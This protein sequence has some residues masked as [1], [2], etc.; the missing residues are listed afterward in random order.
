MTL[1]VTTETIDY[2]NA[3][4]IRVA[5]DSGLLEKKDTLTLVGG[6]DSLLL[7]D[8]VVKI[9]AL[10]ANGV[11]LT[12]VSPVTY[13]RLVTGSPITVT[14]TQLVSNFA[15][16]GRSL[17]FWPTHG[18]DD[19][20]LTAIYTYRPEPIDS[21]STL[22]LTGMGEHLVEQLSGAYFLLDDGQPE[23][24]GGELANYFSQVNRLRGRQDRRIGGSGVLRQAGRRRPP[25]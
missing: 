20:T 23:L 25:N 15:N 3:A 18:P 16:I 11:A 12:E 5:A 7:P 10:Y 9:R 14:N 2:I 24:A 13:M 8:E 19:I 1:T 17:Y 22:E 21:D 4:Q 6:E